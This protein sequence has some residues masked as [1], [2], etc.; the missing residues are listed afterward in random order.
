M[1]AQSSAQ[2]QAILWG[3]VLIVAIVVL[4][5]VVWGIRRWLFGVRT[6]EAPESWSLQHLRELRASGQISPEEFEI[7]RANLLKSARKSGGGGGE[8]SGGRRSAGAE[9][10]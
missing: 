9:S 7:L 2:S 10:E 6:E 5:V 4:G 3:G 8:P 1:I